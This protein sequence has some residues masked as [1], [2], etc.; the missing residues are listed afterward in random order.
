MVWE[1]K[2]KFESQ[3]ADFLGPKICL[4]QFFYRYGLKVTRKENKG[5]IYCKKKILKIVDF[6]TSF[7]YFNKIF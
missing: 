5:L 6:V 1:P 3:N 7:E 2:G 4:D